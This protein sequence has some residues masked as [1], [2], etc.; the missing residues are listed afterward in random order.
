MTA[1]APYRS[2]LGAGRDG[3]PQL[4]R[5]EGTKFRTVRGWL[6]ALVVGGLLIVGLGVLTGAGSVC[7]ENN[8]AC[9]TPPTGPGGEW[10]TDSFYF[11]HQPL[12][13]NGALTVRVTSLTGL[14]STH[15]FPAGGG[16]PTAD[17]TPGVQPWSKAG[18]IIKAGTAPGSAYA[19]MMVTGAHGVRMQWD[20]TG[21]TAGLAGKVS[22]ASPR[23][24]RL[25]RAGDVV[26][27]YDSA[28][29][30]HW[31]LVGTVTLAGL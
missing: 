14:Y 5:A 26:R 8:H 23:W 6:I 19:A 12:G 28:D 22:A 16:S 7:S 4:L 30:T 21:D 29:G 17:M 2:E 3:F 31:T 10:V 20:F 9:P 15:G 1:V 27:G 18:I 24:L 25:T 13:G 11:A